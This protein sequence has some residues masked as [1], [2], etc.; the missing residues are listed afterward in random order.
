MSFKLCSN[1]LLLPHRWQGSTSNLLFRWFLCI[2][3]EVN[4]PKAINGAPAATF[5]SEQTEMPLL[6]LSEHFLQMYGLHCIFHVGR[7]N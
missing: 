1:H 5:G 7:V 3:K 4:P 2:E 6:Q